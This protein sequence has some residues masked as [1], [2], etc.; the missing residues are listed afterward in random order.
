MSLRENLA[1]TGNNVEEQRKEQIKASE[2]KKLSSVRKSIDRLDKKGDKLKSQSTA[3][4]ETYDLAGKELAHFKEAQK[5]I[6]GLY[7]KHKGIL[8]SEDGIETK[9]ELI[10]SSRYGKEEEIKDYKGSRQE[11]KRIIGKARK[12]KEN[13]KRQGIEKTARKFVSEEVSKKSNEI[14][15]EVEDLKLQTPEGQEERKQEF[16]SKIKGHLKEGRWDNPIDEIC[17][18]EKEYLDEVKSYGEGGEQI[19]KQVIKEHFQEE[20]EEIKLLRKIDQELNLLKNFESGYINLS[21]KIKELKNLKEDLPNILAKEIEKNSKLKKACWNYFEN[22]NTSEILQSAFFSDYLSRDVDGWFSN[23]EDLYKDGQEIVDS[24]YSHLENEI[25][26]ITLNEDTE[27]MLGLFNGLEKNL[28]KEL[29]SY[30]KNEGKTDISIKLEEIFLKSKADYLFKP[31]EE[32]KEIL[33]QKGLREAKEESEENV[34]QVEAKLSSKI[35]LDWLKMEKDLFERKNRIWEIEDKKRI[36]EKRKELAEKLFS[37]LDEAEKNLNER[38][39]EVIGI[40]DVRRREGTEFFYSPKVRD[41]IDQI[42]NQIEEKKE[43][44]KNNSNQIEEKN[45][46]SRKIRK[47][48]WQAEMNSLKSEKESLNGELEELKETYREQRD[49]ESQLEG[50]SKILRDLDLSQEFDGKELAIGDTLKMLRDKLTSIQSKEDLSSGEQVIY[51]NWQKL[52]TQEKEAE[53]KYSQSAEKLPN[54]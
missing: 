32:V 49:R 24:D 52:E 46:Q 47:G 37:N 16:K 3:L 21:S 36:I 51:Q 44:I 40:D 4:G 23:A 41:S 22:G 54:F 39:E 18:V 34:K 53:D 10:E 8:A 19:A 42:E 5:I 1:E 9:Q 14:G 13:L 29:F 2:E 27:K 15:K 30:M 11:L 45:N 43:K 26:A 35:N 20:N 17:F 48:K 31:Q 12:I 7:N 33:Q 28:T 6:D 50:L 38:L 25:L